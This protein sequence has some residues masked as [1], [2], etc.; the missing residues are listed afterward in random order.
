MNKK[1]LKLVSQTMHW[2]IHTLLLFTCAQCSRC[3]WISNLFKHIIVTTEGHKKHTW[4]MYTVLYPLAWRLIAVSKSS[5]MLPHVK[6]WFACSASFLIRTPVPTHWAESRPSLQAPEVK[7]SDRNLFECILKICIIFR[8]NNYSIIY[9]IQALIHDNFE[10]IYCAKLT[11]DNRH[12]EIS[13]IYL[14]DHA[15][16]FLR[17]VYV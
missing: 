8:C 9:D 6:P 17:R 2:R 14:S 12:E 15:D 13:H 3:W 1:I 11:T 4:L 10:G 7:Y 5:V 16:T